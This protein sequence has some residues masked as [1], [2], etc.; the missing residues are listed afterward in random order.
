MQHPVRG[1]KSTNNVLRDERVNH[2]LAIHTLT[3]SKY[4][5]CQRLFFKELSVDKVRL[6]ENDCSGT[7]KIRIVRIRFNN[8]QANLVSRVI[9]HLLL[10]KYTE[11]ERCDKK[12]KTKELFDISTCVK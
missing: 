8:L 12:S 6:K 7:P 2:Y 5:G 11:L 1:E 4:N 3:G 10:D 9:G